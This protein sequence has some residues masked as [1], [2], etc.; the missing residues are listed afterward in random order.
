[1]ANRCW[2]PE[3]FARVV[4]EIQGPA[5]LRAVLVGGAAE[6]A[7]ADRVRAAVAAEPVDLVEKLSF[8]ALLA[9][10][11]QCRLYVGND[12]GPMHLAAAAGAP[13]VALFGLQSP[14]L[15][16]PVGAGHVVV[17]PSMPCPCPWPEV[18]RP[19]EPNATLCVR[20][21]AVEDAIAAV[22]K[23]LARQAA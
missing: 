21:N 5:R 7:A 18:C 22:R 1:V 12:T 19:P 16:G 14:E 3:R 9:L 2:P 23:V 10:L 15:W 6:R 8:G 4:D 13:V 11:Q 17:R 20:R